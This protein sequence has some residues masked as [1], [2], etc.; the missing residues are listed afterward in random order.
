MY[1]IERSDDMNF[2][3]SK[4]IIVK[5]ATGKDLK[6][7]YLTYEG[8]EKHPLKIHYIAK[9]GFQKRVLIVNHLIK[10]SELKLFY[11]KNNYKEELL[12]YDNL[13]SHDLRTLTLSISL[14]DDKLFTSIAFNIKNY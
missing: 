3:P 7:I 12:A 4:D 11:Y 5:N 2:L 1:N 13:N 14:K 10:P 8:L 9:G 6:D